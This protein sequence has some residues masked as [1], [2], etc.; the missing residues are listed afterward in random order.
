MGTLRDVDPT[1]KLLAVKQ[2]E[3][4]ENKLVELGRIRTLLTSYSMPD[5]A[6][7]AKNLGVGSIP[8]NGF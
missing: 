4:I 5:V 2:V 7:R 6:E 8:A 1:T 3:V